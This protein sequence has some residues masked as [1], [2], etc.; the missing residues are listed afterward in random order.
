L[1]GTDSQ[2]FDE[3]EQGA[4]GLMLNRRGSASAVLHTRVPAGG[5]WHAERPLDRWEAAVEN[6]RLDRQLW[7]EDRPLRKA[8]NQSPFIEDEVVMETLNSSGAPRVPWNKGRLTGQK[9]PLKLGEIWAIRTRLQMS[10]NAR[11]L[12]LFYLAI[13]SKLR[14]AI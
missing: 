6:R 8:Q 7:V 9:P 13:D 5:L 1:Y 11:E 2:R 4:V 14:R 12:A 3:N 10:S